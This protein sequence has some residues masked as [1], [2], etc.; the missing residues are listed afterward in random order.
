MKQL[1]GDVSNPNNHRAPSLWRNRHIWFL[2]LLILATA[3]FVYLDSVLAFTG[4]SD[5]GWD[6]FG[7]INI[8]HWL[9][10][11]PPILYAA[12]I[13]GVRGTIIVTLIIILVSIP[14]SLFLSADRQHLFADTSFITLAGAVGA[15]IAFLRSQREYI[16]KAY[17]AAVKSREALQ[18]SKEFIETVLESIN[19]SIYVVDTT[20]F[21]IA[22]TN[23]AFLNTL[24]MEEK[25][26][27]GRSCYEVTHHRSKPCEAPNDTC[28][29]AETLKTGYHSTAEHMHYDKNG[30]EIYVQVSTS[31][32]KNEKGEIHQVVHVTHDITERKQA[33]E[34]LRETQRRFRDLADLL[35]QSVWEIDERGTFT[36]ANREAFRSHGYVPEELT[37]PLNAI[38]TFVPEDRDRVAGNV[39][40]ILSGEDLG[41]VEYTALR[42]DDSTFPVVVYAAPIIRDNKAVGLRGVTVD[43]TE[44][45]QAEEKEKQLQQELNLSSRLASIGQMASGVAHE[46]NNPLTGVIGFSQLLMS[47]DIPDDIRGDLQVIN[48][49]AQRVARVVAGLLTFARQRQPGREYV[50]INGI[51]SGV[52]ELRS[53]EMKVNNIKVEVQLAADLP[54]TM[55]DANQLQQ[56]FLNI[57]LNAEKEMTTA[58]KRGKL[59]VKTEKTG[60]NIRVS[61]T[62]DGPGISRENLDR[63]F[64]P[65]FTTREVGNGTGLGLSI[66]H[67]IITQHN[68]RIYARSEAGKGATFVV[69]LPIVADTGQTEETKVIEEE[70]WQQSGAKILVVDDEAAILDFLEHLLTEQGYQVETTDRA[71]AA[72]QRLHNQNYDLILL[73]IKLP[74]M[75]GIDL[76]YQ[77][78][79][80]DPAQAQKVIFI[81]GDV[82]EPTTRDFLDKTKMPHIAKPFNIEQL[83]QEI[84]RMLIKDMAL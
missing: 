84:N 2:T 7:V 5:A 71:Q 48:S 76:Y 18:E 29:L 51:L 16:H 66:C 74:G 45:K 75:S 62:D 26:V 11:F 37:E 4:L 47:K 42:K 14:D 43:I 63:V 15:F 6:T 8:L 17:T 12:Y 70:P 81:T 68:G 30:R 52:L 65:F 55:A 59:L 23:R 38:Q 25:D 27:I 28:P 69:E 67:G 13:F 54:E 31:P 35:P 3:I 80:I 36:F 33:E 60:D 50:D 83:K 53:Y 40:A 22:V 39:Q 19:D 20:D 41:G 46:I 10:H 21:R 78:A 32:I 44:H 24:K 77:I 49:E 61:I 73:D 1:V 9:L 64:D 34:Q 72:L 58:H 57:V 82:M 79:A 56:V